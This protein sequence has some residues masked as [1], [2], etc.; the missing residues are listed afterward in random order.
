MEIKQRIFVDDKDFLIDNNGKK[1]TRLGFDEIKF[2][3]NNLVFYRLGDFCNIVSKN[4][5]ETHK[6]KKDYLISAK[7]IKCYKHENFCVLTTEEN[8]G[9]L[10]I[11]TND[12]EEKLFFSTQLILNE[13]TKYFCFKTGDEIV[14]ILNDATIQKTTLNNQ[15]DLH[16]ACLFTGN[17]SKQSKL[18]N[19][20]E[21]LTS[22]F[23]ILKLILKED[24]KNFNNP[25]YK[26][27][28]LEYGNGEFKPVWGKL[29]KSIDSYSISL[30]KKQ[31]DSQ[32]QAEI[33]AKNVLNFYQTKLQAIIDRRT[34]THQPQ[35]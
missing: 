20:G 9:N 10:K 19:N 21:D 29:N 7:Y 14:F 30:S 13:K 5:V 4:F 2:I 23:N 12:G 17:L 28:L 24:I 1:H 22:L 32:L 25:T 27:V 3:G 35:V 31:F 34:P 18:I 11:V 16:D 8:G 33:N 26:Y 15:T 6:S